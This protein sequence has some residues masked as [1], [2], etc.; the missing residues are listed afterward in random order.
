MALWIG[1]DRIYIY[2]IQ[3]DMDWIW[4]CWHGYGLASDSKFSYPSTTAVHV[5]SNISSDASSR[6]RLPCRD[7][8]L[9]HTGIRTR[10][11]DEF[12][13]KVTR[14]IFLCSQETPTSAITFTQA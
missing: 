6:R 12:P 13:T 1:M 8:Q 9:V 11:K 7:V 5:H 2:E 4:I 3:L 10:V 14:Q